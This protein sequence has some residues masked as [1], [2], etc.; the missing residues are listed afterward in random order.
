MADKF[1]G[2][3]AGY[4][5][6]VRPAYLPQ[7]DY[8][9]YALAHHA[10]QAPPSKPAHDPCRSW[11]RLGTPDRGLGPCE[12]RVRAGAYHRLPDSLC[13]CP[14]PRCLRVT[15]PARRTPVA[16][17]RR[18]W[19]P[20][21]SWGWTLRSHRWATLLPGALC[22]DSGYDVHATHLLQTT[23]WSTCSRCRTCICSSA[24]HSTA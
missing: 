21:R 20:S 9:P 18:W 23:S 8:H 17:P 13:C 19:H 22:A 10:L 2:A 15:S 14:A 4:T 11:C 3:F 7:R 12:E 1:P 5:L 16:Q 6:K 24:P